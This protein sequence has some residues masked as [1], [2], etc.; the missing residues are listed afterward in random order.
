LSKNISSLITATPN[1]A[2]MAHGVDEV[3]SSLGVELAFSPGAFF[4]AGG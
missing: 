4:A 2:M 1:K 3:G